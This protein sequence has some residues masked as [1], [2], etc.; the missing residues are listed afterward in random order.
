MSA[1][2]MFRADFRQVAAK[3]LSEHTGRVQSLSSRGCRIFARCQPQPGAQV[4]LRLYLPSEAS[5]IRVDHAK[6]TRGYWDLFTVEFLDLPASEQE[7][8]K[9]YLSVATA[10]AGIV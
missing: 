3:T 9:D 10:H 1:E 8:L 5:P 2:I 4:E 6:V 7:R